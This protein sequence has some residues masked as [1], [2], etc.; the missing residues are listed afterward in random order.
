MSDPLDRYLDSLLVELGGR[1]PDV[2]RVLA[3]VEDHL[4]DLTNEDERDGATR[5]EAERRAI[6][7]MGDPRAVTRR[8]SPVPRAATLRQLA[9]SLVLLAG[10]GLVAVGASG[11]LAAGMGA[12]FGHDFVAGDPSGVTYTKAR[13]DYFLEYYPQEHTC[14]K[15]ATAHHYDE[16]VMYR[17]GAGVLGLLVLGGALLGRRRWR[18]DDLLLPDGFVPT[19]AVALFGAAAAYLLLD[20]FGLAVIG[21]ET[22]GVGQWLSAGLVAAVMAVVYLVPLSRKLLTRPAN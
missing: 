7:Q 1:A 13:C 4:I 19:I 20:S 16:V 10:I 6:A 2:R 8:F 12:A 5:D 22:A 15:A 3:E 21:G 17:V 11:P 18:S 9:L 14:A